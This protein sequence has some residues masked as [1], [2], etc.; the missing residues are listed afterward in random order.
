MNTTHELT[1]SRTIPAAMETAFEAWL[2]P[3]A[4]AQFIKPMAGMVDCDVEADATEGGRFLI[5]MKFGDKEMP[6]SG[7]YQTI[8]RFEKLVFTWNS[9]HTGSDS[10]V[11][12]RFREL[13]PQETELTLHHEGLPSE[14][15]RDNHNG[16]WKTILEQLAGFVA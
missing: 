7:Q 1:I 4:L 9:E 15:S 6:H 3:R 12:L 14:E 10:V 5:M 11:T 2:D 16:G 13:G 8:Q